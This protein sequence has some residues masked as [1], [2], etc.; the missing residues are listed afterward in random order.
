MSRVADDVRGARE[1]VGALRG[2]LDR[3]KARIN[4]LM[5]AMITLSNKV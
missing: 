2:S 1:E 4:D 3:A 5:E